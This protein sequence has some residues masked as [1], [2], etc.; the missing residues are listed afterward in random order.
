MQTVSD[1]LNA[2]RTK[3]KRL[4]AHLTMIVHGDLIAPG[5]TDPK[6]IAEHLLDHVARLDHDLAGVAAGHAQLA[7]NVRR[8]AEAFG[9][10]LGFAPPAEQRECHGVAV[11]V[12][13]FGMGDG[14]TTTP[15]NGK[16]SR[17]PGRFESAVR[18]ERAG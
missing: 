18:G 6:K 11:A 15:T 7:G 17:I 12:M 16:A 10:E 1:H 4:E 5:M 14:P 9:R 3:L 13:P 2:A 8:E